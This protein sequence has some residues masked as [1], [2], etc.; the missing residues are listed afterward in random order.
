MFGRKRSLPR[1]PMTETFEAYRTRVLSYLGDVRENFSE[2]TLVEAHVRTASRDI[3]EAFT[4]CTT[5]DGF[6]VWLEYTPSQQV[7]KFTLAATFRSPNAEKIPYARISNFEAQGVTCHPNPKGVQV[8][9]PTQRFSCTRQN[10]DE[11]RIALSSDDYDPDGAGEL[12]LSAIQKPQVASN[13]GLTVSGQ[14]VP[15]DF[16]PQNGPQVP[17]CGCGSNEVVFPGTHD[18]GVN[19]D[20]PFR[21]DAANM[22][23]KQGFDRYFGVV[24]WGSSY[25]TLSNNNRADFPGIA[26]TVKA[27]FNKT[28]DYNVFVHVTVD[29][30]DV[31]CRNTCR[32]EGTTQIHVR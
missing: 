30:L 1:G 20:F 15:I 9:R 8:K 7:R 5:T 4:K 17:G 14:S 19:Q 11:L 31:N 6:H 21:Y 23:R 10:N 12:T 2:H 13:E 32:A 28:G 26:G 29:C 22:C 25:T 18:V 3:L 27:K 24:L 16:T